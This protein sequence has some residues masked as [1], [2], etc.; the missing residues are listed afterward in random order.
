[1][2]KNG[3]VVNGGFPGPL[4]EANWGDWIKV[5]VKNSLTDEGTALHW[6][7]L[8][9]KETQWFDGVPSV[10]QCPI[11]PGKSMTYLFRADMYGTSWVSSPTTTLTTKNCLYS[12]QYECSTILITQHSMLEERLVRW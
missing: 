8:L 7:G 11:A 2:T 3:L 1:V 4:I 12:N 6:H 9:Q 10:G 5:N